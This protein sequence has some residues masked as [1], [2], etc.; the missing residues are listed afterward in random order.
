M[1]LIWAAAIV[2]LIVGIITALIGLVGCWGACCQKTSLL[3]LV[4]RFFNQLSSLN[5]F[6]LFKGFLCVFACFTYLGPVCL[7]CVL[8]VFS[9]VCF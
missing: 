7:F 4:S 8:G 2:A 5:S 3:N 9:L 6:A 1:H